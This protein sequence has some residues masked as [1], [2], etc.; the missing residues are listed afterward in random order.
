MQSNQL[1]VHSHMAWH[2]EQYLFRLTSTFGWDDAISLCDSIVS[3]IESSAPAG[4]D[5]RRND[6]H[7]L[8][9]PYDVGN[10]DDDDDDGIPSYYNDSISDHPNPHQ[11]SFNEWI[12][13]AISQITYQDQWGNTPLHAA[14]FVKP[15][16]DVIHALFRVGRTLMKYKIIVALEASRNSPSAKLLNSGV[17]EPLWAVQ[18]KDGSTSFLVACSTGASTLI[19]HRFLDEVEYYIDQ[20]WLSNPNVARMLVLQSDYNTAMQYNSNSPIKG[21]MDFHKGWIERQLGRMDEDNSS[22]SLQTTNNRNSNRLN[23]NSN[24]QR[25]RFGNNHLPRH[26]REEA[27]LS[28]SEYWRL[29]CRMLLFATMHIFTGEDEQ[30]ITQCITSPARIAPNTTTLMHRC[31]AIA[32]YCPVSLLEW[33]VTKYYYMPPLQN[34]NSTNNGIDDER[35]TDSGKAWNPS[36]MCAA[37]P[38]RM[39]RLPLHLAMEGT[40]LFLDEQTV[41][42]KDGKTAAKECNANGDGKSDLYAKHTGSHNAHEATTST[43]PT[44][45]ETTNPQQI[46]QELLEWYPQSEKFVDGFTFTTRA[47]KSTATHDTAAMSASTEAAMTTLKSIE[48]AAECTITSKYYSAGL[49][50]NRFKL[51]E[52]LLRWHPPSVV[53]PFPSSGRSPLC[54]AIANGG[55]WHKLG[56]LLHRPFQNS[57]MEDDDRVMGLVQLL[58]RYAPEKLSERDSVTGLYPFMLAATVVSPTI[59]TGLPYPV[60]SHDCLGVDTIYNLLRKDPQLVGTALSLTQDAGAHNLNMMM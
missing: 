33:I 12:S 38:D 27:L 59:P 49:E 26:V 52:M 15:P 9:N 11:K 35:N 58:W 42:G 56:T 28:L 16:V 4:T 54:Q 30:V 3:G 55:Y 46:I 21:W 20:K 60:I 41:C 24:N 36:Q 40:Y 32:P 5:R 53:V 44:Q 25:S 23:H 57:A 51:I 14:S 34:N 1:D 18:S 45:K 43:T 48:T 19:L 6:D 13:H 22:S 8:A 31:A 50:G 2:D 47:K 39:G 7:H 37:T 29:A 10:D 17:Q